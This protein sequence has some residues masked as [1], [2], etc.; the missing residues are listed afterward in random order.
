MTQKIPSLRTKTKRGKLLRPLYVLALRMTAGLTQTDA[1]NVV[2]VNERTW[3]KWEAEEGGKNH[4]YPGE[5]YIELFCRKLGLTY[6][7]QF[8]QQEEE[9]GAKA[10]A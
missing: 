1:A 9:K 8:N 6:P 4:R 5:A 2:H 10:A 7:P 3:R